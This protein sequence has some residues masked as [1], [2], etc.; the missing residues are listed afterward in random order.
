MDRLKRAAIITSLIESLRERNSWCGETHVQKTALFLQELM[1]VP[2]GFEFILYKHGPFSF[3]LR[4]ELTSYRADELIVLEPQWPYGPRIATTSRSSYIQGINSKT[5]A[6]YK[7]CI[8][9]VAE[10]FANKG[11]ADLER[12]AT[13]YYLTQRAEAG[14]SVA[15]RAKEIT[16]V[17]PHISK[18]DAQAAVK[19]V[20]QI[21]EE[22]RAI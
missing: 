16:E 19:D 8:S 9:F 6:Q 2:L 22:V 5:L 18:E 10:K 14:T 17:K 21:I 12:L 11:V 20:D 1:E 7:S 3:D 13:A 15:K 4:D